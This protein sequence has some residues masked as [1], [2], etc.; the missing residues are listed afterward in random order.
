MP[1]RREYLK[2]LYI[3]LTTILYNYAA[4]LPENRLS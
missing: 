2:L 3:F 1:L 4:Q